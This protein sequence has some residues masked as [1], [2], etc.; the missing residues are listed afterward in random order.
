MSYSWRNLKVISY[1][2]L[3]SGVTGIG[4]SLLFN[5]DKLVVLPFF[6]DALDATCIIAAGMLLLTE[7]LREASRPKLA[8]N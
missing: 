5:L 6:P 7:M 2:L 4:V 8:R 1:A 3:G